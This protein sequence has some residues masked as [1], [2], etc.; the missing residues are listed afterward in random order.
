[1]RVYVI[2]HG[3]SESNHKK[4]WSGQMDVRLTDK[5]REDAAL[6]GEFLRGVQIDKVYA[7]DLIRAQETAQI[8]LPGREL[9]LSPLM[10]EIDMGSLTGRPHSEL[11]TEIRKQNGV[12]GYEKYGGESR[13]EIRERVRVVMKML[14]EAGDETAAIFAHGGF[15]RAMLDVVLEILVPREHLSCKNCAVAVFDCKDG[16]WSLYSWVNLT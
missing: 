5:G 14:E 3:Q 8:A 10:R 7:S 12:E 9:S 1:M 2:R 4:I 13:D 6:A 16:N 11:S 15:L